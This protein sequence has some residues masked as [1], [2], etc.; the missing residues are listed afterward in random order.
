[1]AELVA[2]F[3]SISG[4]D[5]ALVVPPALLAV[6]GVAPGGPGRLTGSAGTEGVDSNPRPGWLDT[7]LPL[8]GSVA[9]C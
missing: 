7:A 9:Y 1:M 6:S 4:D 3:A 5:S 8:P 2:E